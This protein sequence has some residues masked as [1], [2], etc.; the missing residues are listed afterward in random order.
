MSNISVRLPGDV[1]EQ[2]QCEAERTHKKRSE[3]VREA[4]LDYLKRSEKER[5]LQDMVAEAKVAYASTEIRRA[6]QEIDE[7]FSAVEDD[8]HDDQTQWWK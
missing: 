6:A 3:I 2:L 7:D 5:F 4:V 1:L 8:Q